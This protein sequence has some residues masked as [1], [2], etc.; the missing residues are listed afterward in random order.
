MSEDQDPQ[1]L[2]IPTPERAHPSFCGKRILPTDGIDPDVVDDIAAER[3]RQDEQWG[4]PDHD[5]RHPDKTGGAEAAQQ[6]WSFLADF[7]RRRTQQ[8]FRLG[9]GGWSDILAE[10]VAK[11]F[12]E[13]DPVLLREKLV[14][15]AA[16]ATAWIESLDRRVAA[17]EL[18]VSGAERS[19]EFP[20]SDPGPR[21][22]VCDLPKG[23]G[24]RRH[25][26][27]PPGAGQLGEPIVWE[28]P[29][30]MGQIRGDD[31]K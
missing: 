17:N 15:V 10:A 11:A 24:G 26:G 13:S 8:F 14:P 28:A 2:R 12:A 21:G 25:Q 23:H 27:R 22:A 20:C 1:S 3:R 29:P 7:Q 5:D 19:V 6:R 30:R 9:R 18:D 31:A 4:G 16:V